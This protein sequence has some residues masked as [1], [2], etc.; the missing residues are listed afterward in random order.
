MTKGTFRR[1]AVPPF[2][3]V[4]VDACALVRRWLAQ[5]L[6]DDLLPVVHHPAY[7]LELD[8]DPPNSNHA[9]RSIAKSLCPPP[10]SRNSLDPLETFACKPSRM[11]GAYSDKG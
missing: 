6:A 3:A 8:T 1:C 11:P 4:D 2:V 5:P 9:P 10:H 7:L